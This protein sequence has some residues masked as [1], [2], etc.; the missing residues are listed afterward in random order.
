MAVCVVTKPYPANR[1]GQLD[2][3]IGVMAD[4]G[5]AAI[6]ANL[7]LRLGLYLLVR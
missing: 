1:R 5:M 3:G 7:V 2:G 6:Y 4:D